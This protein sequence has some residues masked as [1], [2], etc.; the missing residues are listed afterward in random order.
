MNTG[1]Q[2]PIQ[3]GAKH[4]THYPSLHIQNNNSLSGSVNIGRE[5]KVQ[6]TTT[7]SLCK[8]DG[9]VLYNYVEYK[10]FQL[11]GLS[12][13]FPLSTTKTGITGCLATLAYYTISQLLHLVYYQ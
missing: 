9:Q 11:C 8:V 1:Q 5:L 10:Y 7:S 6:E 2:L 4:L 3:T 13:F 12:F